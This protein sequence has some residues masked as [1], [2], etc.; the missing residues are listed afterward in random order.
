[1][2]GG[3][4]VVWTIDGPKPDGGG[5]M[6]GVPAFAVALSIVFVVVGDNMGV[7]A[8]V[9]P[10]DAGG[11]DENVAAFMSDDCCGIIKETLLFGGTILIGCCCCEGGGCCKFVS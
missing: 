8:G 9:F 4:V 11:G 3:G 6:N 1:M 5:D 7:L 2:T 10:N